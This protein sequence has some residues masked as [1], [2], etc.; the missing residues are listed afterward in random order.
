MLK[1]PILTYRRY[2]DVIEVYKIQIN[3]YNNLKIPKLRLNK[4]R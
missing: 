3:K 2:G 4:F 1:L